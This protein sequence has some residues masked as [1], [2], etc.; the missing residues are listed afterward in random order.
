[1]GSLTALK[2]KNQR[3]VYRLTLVAG[4]NAE[5]ATEYAKLI[6]L[7]KPDF[8]EIKAGLYTLHAVDP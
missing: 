3:T 2:D 7:G 1:V 5:D 6:D 4:W 8:I